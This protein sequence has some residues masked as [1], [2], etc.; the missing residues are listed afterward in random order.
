VFGERPCVNA[1]TSMR[2]KCPQPPPLQRKHRV[3]PPTRTGRD[4]R[5]ALACPAI[6][7]LDGLTLA[8]STLHADR[9]AHIVRH[10]HRRSRRASARSTSD[11]VDG[12]TQ[13][14]SA[15]SVLSL[16]MHLNVPS[17]RPSCQADCD[18]PMK[19][20]NRVFAA[21]LSVESTPRTVVRER[22]ERSVT[23]ETSANS[24][25]LMSR[26]SLL[27]EGLRCRHG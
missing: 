23:D 7:A 1:P 9:N 25:V 19:P 14:E 3:R 17:E 24:L 27:A 4:S 12:P 13:P 18:G 20:G 11:E 21:I 8:R 22:G 5:T 10:G 26:F 16:Q 2:P 15:E 6:P